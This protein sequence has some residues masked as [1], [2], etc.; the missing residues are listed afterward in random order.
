[1]KYC[2]NC[3]SDQ[4]KF[5][6][7][8]GDTYK[9]FVCDNCNSIHYDNPRVI[10]GCLPIYNHKIVICKRAIEPCI[11]KWNLPAG[12]M[13]NGESVHEAA[14][15]ET[16]EEANAR[17]ELQGLY[18]LFNLPHANQVFI[19]YR[20]RLLDLDYS[21]GEESLEVVLFREDEIPWQ[22]IAFSMVE[23]TLRLYFRE[24]DNGGFETHTR[25][26]VRISKEPRRYRIETP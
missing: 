16:L 19:I 13:E 8:E 17:I 10:V 18:T 23:E 2:S 20:G 14:V 6:I 11:G 3:G 5:I 7:P 24:R 9:R 22:D 12:F 1:L 15:R 21:P 26:I 4:I 25:T